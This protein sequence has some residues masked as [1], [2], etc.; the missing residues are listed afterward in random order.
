MSV[1]YL[2]DTMAV[3]EPMKSRANRAAVD[4]LTSLEQSQSFLSILTIGEIERGILKIEARETRPATRYRDALDSILDDFGTR[5]LMI[6]RP[7]IGIWASLTF[8][9]KHTNP[10]LLIAA[11]ALAHDLTVVTR[12][13]SHFAP[14]GAKLFNPYQ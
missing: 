3:S 9:L 2:L 7:V 1:G 13:T 14:T 5:I 4:W 12:N 8:K 10:D 6:D 11:T